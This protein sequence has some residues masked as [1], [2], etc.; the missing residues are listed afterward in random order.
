MPEGRDS[1][2]GV[3]GGEGG[4]MYNPKVGMTNNLSPSVANIET[5]NNLSPSLANARLDS[6]PYGQT[7][8]RWYLDYP[9]LGLQP[10][11]MTVTLGESLG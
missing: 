9:P 3:Y 10:P 8:N 11:H 5:M 4:W 7:P 1:D 2:T 6:L